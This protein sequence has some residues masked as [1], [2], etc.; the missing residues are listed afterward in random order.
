MPAQ[1]GVRPMRVPDVGTAGSVAWNQGLQPRLNITTGIQPPQPRSQERVHASEAGD[2]KKPIYEQTVLERIADGLN[3]T[4][5]AVDKRLKFLVHEETERVYVQV[6]DKETGEVIKEI[7]PEKILNLVAQLQK[8][9]G[10]LIDE[11]A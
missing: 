7:P 1:R 11:W 10:L 6:I 8:L 5:E 9:I 2:E 4:L 3:R